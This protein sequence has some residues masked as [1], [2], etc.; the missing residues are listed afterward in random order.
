MD[1]DE[2]IY[3]WKMIYQG[4]DKPWVVFKYGTCVLLSNY[5]SGDIEQQAKEK[6]K[7]WGAVVAGTPSS[8]YGFHFLC[9]QGIPGCLISCHHPDISTYIDPTESSVEP[10]KKM[11]GIKK[12]LG[13]FG[14]QER[15][16]DA[17]VLHVIYVHK[18]AN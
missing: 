15:H 12:L 3:V 1:P 13:E 2:L 9:E 5:V 7:K 17:Q 14:R 16:T 8:K 6:L 10:S 18:P 4:F 11:E